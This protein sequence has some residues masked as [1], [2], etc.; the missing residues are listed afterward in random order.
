MFL[1]SLRSLGSAQ[2]TTYLVE[3]NRIE[4]HIA[5]ILLEVQALLVDGHAAVAGQRILPPVRIQRHQHLGAACAHVPSLLARMVYQVEV[6]DIRRK[7]SS[8]H[9]TPCRRCFSKAHI[10]G[11]RPEP[12]TVATLML[13][14]FDHAR[15]RATFPPVDRGQVSCRIWRSSLRRVLERR[16]FLLM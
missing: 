16:N 11:L 14:P 15:P 5:T 7:S 1:T 9:R 8:A 6:G 2:R 13:N 3:G 10:G 12:F 4:D